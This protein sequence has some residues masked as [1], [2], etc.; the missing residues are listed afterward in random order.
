MISFSRQIKNDILKAEIGAYCCSSAELCAYIMLI[1][2]KKESSIE[3]QLDDEI[4]ANRI[5]MLVIKVLKIN[6]R[7][8]KLGSVYSL[9][10]NL[11]PKFFEKYGFLFENNNKDKILCVYKKSCCRAAFLKGVFLA[12]GVLVNPEKN[13]NLEF[14]IKSYDNCM[15]ISCL[16]EEMGIEMKHTKRKRNN[17]LYV[18]N[19]DTICDILTYVGAYSAQMKI[20]NLKIEREVRSDLNRAS[21]GETA[22]MDKTIKA[23]IKHIKAIEK[24]E[25]TKGLDY[26]PEEL[27]ETAKLRLEYRD[28]S[29]RELADKHKD[30]ISKSGI[31][32]RLN[33]IVFIAEN[34]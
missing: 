28:L 19:S 7:P 8:I 5:S 1:G 22:N 18:K 27:Y 16:A 21:N 34:M 20:L 15:T 17:I 25:K 10:V 9:M 12:T 14:S 6:T 11:T 31:N 24:I 2:K 13:Y 29:I 23:S 32:H 30:P 3:F 33:K 4:F 26:L